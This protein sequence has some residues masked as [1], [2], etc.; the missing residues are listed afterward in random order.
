M[1]LNGI[2]GLSEDDNVDSDCPLEGNGKTMTM[3]KNIAVEVFRTKYQAV[4][5]YNTKIPDSVKLSLKEMVKEFKDDIDRQKRKQPL[6]FTHKVI[7]IDEMSTSGLSSLGTTKA[8]S[9]FYGMLLNQS[10]KA[11]LI[12]FYTQQR[13]KDLLKSLRQHTNNICMPEKYH[14]SDNSI[15]LNSNC[16]RKDHYIQVFRI[17]PKPY[18]LVD[19]IDCQKW[20]NLYNTKDYVSMENLT[21]ND[22]SSVLNK[23]VK[24]GRVVHED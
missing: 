18:K 1:G 5:N 24:K 8:V 21:D 9:D 14:Y 23:K 12:I 2:V 19:I 11:D 13:F 15:C 4:T 17:K 16:N 22:L 20:G 3:T 10:R 6:Q 7:G